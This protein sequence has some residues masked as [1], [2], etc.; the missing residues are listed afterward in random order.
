MSRESVD[1]GPRQC[2]HWVMLQ[3]RAIQI[4]EQRARQAHSGTDDP[5][6]SRGKE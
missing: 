2:Y 3:H 4:E 6:T 1:G 5:L